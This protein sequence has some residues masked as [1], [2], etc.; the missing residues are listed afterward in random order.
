MKST[1]SL[2]PMKFANPSAKRPLAAL[3]RSLFTAASVMRLPARK[4]SSGI[5]ECRNAG[6][7]RFAALLAQI[8]LPILICQF[9]PRSAAAEAAPVAQPAAAATNLAGV[10]ADLAWKQLQKSFRPPAPPESWR[11][12][13][14]TLEE[15][16]AFN[17]RNGELAAQVAD[18]AS[19]F[20]TR[21][22]DHP[23]AQEARQKELEMRKTAVQLGNTKQVARLNELQDASA[24]D[25][26]SESEDSFLVRWKAIEREAM[27][28][29]PA[30]SPAFL[31]EVQKGAFALRKEFPERS[32]VYDLMMQLLQIRSQA[33]D[34]DNVRTLAQPLIESSIR[35]EAKESVRQMIKKFDYLG[36]PLQLK[37]TAVD[38]R[39]VDLEKMRGKVVL[40][41]FWASWCAPC[42][43]EMPKVKS[44]Y[45]KLHPQGFEIIGINLDED[46]AQM[47]RALTSSKMTWPQSF[48]GRKWETPLVKRF[49]IMSIPTVWLVD[50][51]G[52]LRDLNARGNLEERVE[53]LL[54]EKTE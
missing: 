44:A 15:R 12:T 8:T 3:A 43:I 26:Q 10:D 4:E 39:E 38:G 6:G 47:Q 42:M 17:K 46:K 50:K 51:R 9:A 25:T 41:D 16:H 35:E 34:A 2:I 1:E 33:G 28:S 40:I 37:F 52:V 31:D 29:G 27:K 36:K 24:K 19:E 45:E 54:Q 7:R 32:E 13:S 30:G 49:G 22:P 23:K 53:K 5:R 21:F 18:L 14:P 48:D 20:Y 11:T